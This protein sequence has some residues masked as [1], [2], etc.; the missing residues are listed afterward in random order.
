MLGAVAAPAPAPIGVVLAGGAAR[1]LG[2]AKAG[3]RLGDRSLAQWVAEALGAVVDE[4]VLAAR[5]DTTMPRLSLPVWREP[6]DGPAHPLAGVASALG[7]AGGRDVLVCPVDLPFV[8]ARLLRLLVRA[9][10]AVAVADGQP[11]L[12]RY[13]AEVGPTLAA[14]A[15]AG[16]PV[17]RVVGALGATVVAA[18]DAERTLLN[19]NTPDDLARAEAM[20]GHSGG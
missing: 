2:G 7:R 19:I 14:A 8:D 9:P 1:R 13:G 3:V 15:R 11:L 12:G 17:R 20:L 6:A 4:V 16:L 18:P 5:A 10:G